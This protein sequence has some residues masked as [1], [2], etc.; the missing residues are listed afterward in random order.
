M[1]LESKISL[2][3]MIVFLLTGP[4]QFLCY[5]SS[6]F[7][8]L[9]FYML[10]LFRPCLFLISPYLFL[11]LVPQWVCVW[12]G[13]GGEGRGGCGGGL[14]FVIAAFPGYLHLLRDCGISWVST[15]AS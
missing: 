13:G 3:P 5:S 11:L 8:H 4:R 7:V 1:F 2:S 14:C 10:R 15:L 9:S 12:G 6:L